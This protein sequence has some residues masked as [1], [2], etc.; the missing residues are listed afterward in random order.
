MTRLA[1]WYGVGMALSLVLNVIYLAIRVVQAQ[2]DLRGQ[3]LAHSITVTMEPMKW[4]AYVVVGGVIIGSV[5]M[6]LSTLVARM[7]SGS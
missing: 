3:D 4:L 5:L 7:R 1:R 6:V 2:R